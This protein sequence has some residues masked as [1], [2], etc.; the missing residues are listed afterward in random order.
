[1]ERCPIRDFDV[2]DMRRRLPEAVSMLAK[3]L[4][5][6]NRVYVHC[7]A[8]IGRAPLTV[9]GYLT[10]VD[11]YSPEEAIQLIQRARPEA[12]PSWEAYYGCWEDLNARYRQAIE[13]RA[14]EIYKAGEHKKPSADWRQAEAEVL[15]SVL[16]PKR[17]V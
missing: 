4:G 13:K 12:M 16:T 10:L 7:T 11:T 17:S 1:M 14:H 8:G 9:L 6:A 5:Q 15:R 3:M 2:S